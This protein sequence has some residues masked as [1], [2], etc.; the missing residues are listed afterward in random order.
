M[1]SVFL[2]AAD[3]SY[4]IGSVFRSIL[5]RSFPCALSEGAAEVVDAGK[6]AFLR[7]CGNGKWRVDQ[8]LLGFADLQVRFLL[9]DLIK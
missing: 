9:M 8:Q 2:R 1:V 3:G 5:G 7:N 6:A 4:L